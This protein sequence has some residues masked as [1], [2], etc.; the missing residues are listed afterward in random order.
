MPPNSSAEN[1]TDPF[2]L[3]MPDR[4]VG[5]ARI[6]AATT[7]ARTELMLCVEGGRAATGEGL[8]AALRVLAREIAALARPNRNDP[9]VAEVQGVVETLLRLG[10]Y[11]APVE[12]PTATLA[13]SWVVRSWS[14]VL[15]AMLVAPAWQVPEA[16]VLD[17][18]PDWLWR[19]YSAWLFQTPTRFAGPSGDTL[20]LHHARH[21]RALERWSARNAGSAS[22]RAAV[23]GFLAGTR[24]V[25]ADASPRVWREQAE[26]R[27][28]VL[29][30]TRVRSRASG[31]LPAV[32]RHGRRL[33]IGFVARD[34]GPGPAMYG[35]LPCFEELDV[36]NF[37]VFLFPLVNSE[38]AE[39]AYC[40]RRGRGM[41][42]LPQGVA[43]RVTQLREAQMDVLVF[44]GD[45][46]R[47]DSEVTE[48]ALH[49][50]APLQV[51]NHRSGLST[52][53]P[54]IDLYVTGFEPTESQPASAYTERVGVLRGPA[55]SIALARSKDE[56]A[57]A[58]GRAE[59]GLPVEATLLVAVVD[60]TG[61]AAPLLRAWVEVLARVPDAHLAIALVHEGTDA[62]VAL[63]CAAVDATLTAAGVDR[64][65]VT[66]FPAAVSRPHEVRALLA[67]GDLYLDA[68]ATGLAAWTTVEA[69]QAGVPVLAAPGRDAEATS[70]F[71][72]ALGLADCVPATVLEIERLAVGLAADTIRRQELRTRLTAAMESGPDFL[73]T[74]AASEAF[75]AL[76]EAAFDE[77]CLL[78]HAEFR[79]Q[80]EPVRCFGVDDPAETVASGFAA[81]ARGDLEG[82]AM[83]AVLALRSA[84]TDLRV[85]HLYGLVLNAQGI[86]S[87][88]VDYLLGAVQRPGATVQMWHDLARALRD[89]H[90]P[91]EA[92]QALET[93]LRMDPRNVE[94]LFM[95]L[96]LSEAIGATEMARDVL[97]CLQQMAP[98]D[99]RVVA[100]S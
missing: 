98:A 43:E 59:V 30:R 61:V 86:T 74:L 25:G 95:L 51:V 66:I 50:L 87:R 3:V 78:G 55:H 46:G 89:N 8:Q 41:L 64:R 6:E 13:R 88:A 45:L 65:R 34:F 75:G 26:L 19:M 10:G 4:E 77:L 100:M 17:D 15:A 73:D 58:A 20:A 11:D 56:T 42:Q 39:A 36:R 70:C 57:A 18:V 37:D 9:W 16:P 68:G 32:S 76:I 71:L 48:L 72:R 28:R 44:V 21:L 53:L 12:A 35:A 97:Q 31:E 49:R 14:G 85:R 84:P 93:C 2:T 1:S 83:D 24:H 94:A 79:R 91:A 80:A 38:A 82:A 52:G 54:E 92:I 99:P 63:F 29:T 69:L 60:A 81:H 40:G 22:L 5:A 27:G 96:E 7:V 62:P 23:A 90:Q 33:R 47:E 67:L